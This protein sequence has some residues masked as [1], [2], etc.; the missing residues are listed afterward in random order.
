MQL[1]DPIVKRKV[2]PRRGPGGLQAD[3][4]SQSFLLPQLSC[5]HST[6]RSFIAFPDSLQQ[7]GRLSKDEQQLARFLKKK[8]RLGRVL[9]NLES[10]KPFTVCPRLAHRKASKEKEKEQVVQ[11]G[12]D[13]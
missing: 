12:Q 7:Q 4:S 2:S 9:A 13:C 1:R 5:R 11:H 10:Q 6:S 8:S 3:P